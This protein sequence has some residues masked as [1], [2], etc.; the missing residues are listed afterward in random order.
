MNRDDSQ[1][2]EYYKDI[3]LDFHR[4]VNHRSVKCCVKLM[5]QTYWNRAKSKKILKE[6]SDVKDYRR[7]C[8]GFQESQIS[9]ENT[10]N[11]F[12]LLNSRNA[13]RYN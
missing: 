3:T 9:N 13:I 1:F 4:S 8:E 2:T 12:Q 7:E 6:V 5:I 11:I 10:K